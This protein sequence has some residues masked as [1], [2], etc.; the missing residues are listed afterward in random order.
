MGLSAVFLCNTTCST[1]KIY[2]PRHLLKKY[3]IHKKKILGCFISLLFNILSKILRV[4][5]KDLRSCNSKLNLILNYNL[6]DLFDISQNIFLGKSLNYKIVEYSKIYSLR[7]QNFS[8]N[9]LE[10]LISVY[11][12]GIDNF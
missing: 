10:G 9:A 3:C 1:S 11:Y 6:Q 12:R 4:K 5:K 2:P 7:I 8:K